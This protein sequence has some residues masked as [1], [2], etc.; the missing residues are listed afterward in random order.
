[1]SLEKGII[2]LSYL[3]KAPMENHIGSYKKGGK[4]YLNENGNIVSVF[5]NPDKIELEL[6]YTL[7]NYFSL[8]DNMAS[9]EE[10]KRI[11]HKLG[12]FGERI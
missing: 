4:I 3:A 9:K 5:Y 12:M 6:D 2:V 10:L 11:K 7:G 1:M 8:I